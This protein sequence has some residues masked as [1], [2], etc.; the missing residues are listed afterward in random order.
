MLYLFATPRNV[1]G[2]PED[3]QP[4]LLLLEDSYSLFFWARSKSRR[5]CVV[6]LDR[7][8]PARQVAWHVAPCCESLLSL[9][10]EF[11]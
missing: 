8:Q 1:Q 11:V 7:S 4:A 3:V 10:W 5:V 2:T 9:F 6:A